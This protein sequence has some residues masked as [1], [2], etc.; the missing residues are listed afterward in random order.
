MGDE[1]L[2]VR[3]GRGGA[4]GAIIYRG[5]GATGKEIRRMKFAA[6][7]V[8]SGESVHERGEVGAKRV[9]QKEG[10]KLCTSARK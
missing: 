9:R 1:S 3:G 5:E 10:K 7:S 8:H 6:V 2:G 4:P